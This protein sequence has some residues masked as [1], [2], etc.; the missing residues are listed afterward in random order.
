MTGIRTNQSFLRSS[1]DEWIVL[2]LG[3]GAGREPGEIQ[4]RVFRKHVV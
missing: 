1:G 2:A 3:R 4:H